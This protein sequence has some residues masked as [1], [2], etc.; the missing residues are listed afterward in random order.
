MTDKDK[1]GW[2]Q[3]GAVK[4]PITEEERSEPKVPQK[5]WEEKIC[6]YLSAAAVTYNGRRYNEE[7]QPKWPTRC[8][9]PKCQRFYLCN[10]E[11]RNY[12]GPSMREKD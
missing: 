8:M 1:S 3:D 2:R 10:Y 4:I 6:I 12:G 5:P 7:N 9:G 11:V